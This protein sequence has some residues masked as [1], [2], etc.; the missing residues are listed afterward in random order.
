[1]TSDSSVASFLFANAAFDLVAIATSAGGLHALEV[2]LTD[3]PKDFPAAIAI[4]QH[5]SPESPGLLAGILNR[6]TPLLVKQAMADD[7]LQAGMVYVAPPDRHL[8][9]NASG[10]IKLAQT[11]RVNFARPSAD[12][13]FTSVA[14]SFRQRAI[15]VILTGRGRDGATG[16]QQIKQLGGTTIAQD[17]TTAEFFDMPRA[18]IQTLA[19]D[20]V[21]PLAEIAP[22]LVKLVWKDKPSC[23]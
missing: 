23:D 20:F 2:I 6:H 16:I 8:L 1:M 9:I 12:V 17:Q 7:R 11:K 13:L 21:L 22:M 15:A 14:Q 3:L 18:A 5:L 4:V 19:V 10:I